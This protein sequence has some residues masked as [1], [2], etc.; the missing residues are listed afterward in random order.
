MSYTVKVVSAET[1]E[2]SDSVVT[3]EKLNADLGTSAGT[4]GPPGPQ[5]PPGPEGPQG[6]QGATGATGLQGPAGNDGAT[7]TT[8]ATGPQGPIG[9]TG[10]KGDKG[11]TGDQGPQGIQGVVGATGPQ[12]PQG[13]PGND[14]ATGP[15]G[16]TGATGPAGADGAQG[17]QG[18]TGAQGIQGIQGP[19]GATGAT[20]IAV[21]MFHSDGGANCT[22]TN[23]ANAEQYL[24]NS[25]RNEIQF[26]GTNFTQ[27]RVSSNIVTLSA[28]VNTPRLYPQ[29]W[30]GSAWTTIGSGTG[31]EAISMA[32]T[33]IKNTSWINLP[34]GAKADV[35]FRI[36]MNGGDATADPAIGMT[37]LQFK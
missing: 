7:G 4:E 18:A 8:G 23:Q 2:A 20:S 10:P 30:N 16:S 27:V 12:G 36:A 13:I 14:G 28:S 9:N 34:S 29:Y 25:S 15:Q 24:A 22:L 3:L 6:P 5:G 37:C 1:S 33:G 11:D 35:R 32:S 31:G 17:P 21:L 19:T 26:D